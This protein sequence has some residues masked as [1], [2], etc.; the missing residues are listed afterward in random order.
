[1]VILDVTAGNR[2]IW[3]NSKHPS[4]IIFIDKEFG[5]KINQDIIAD[6]RKL[7]I[8]KDIQIDSIIFD[9][10]WGLNMPPWWVDKNPNDVT[11]TYYGDFKSKRELISYIHKA[12]K[13]FQQ[14]T[15]R[16]C[17][18][19]GERN[20]SLWKILPLFTREGWIEINRKEI[21]EKRNAKGASSNKNW[22]I[23]FMR[24]KSTCGE[25]EK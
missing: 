1:M 20:V 25:D 15:N 18:K 2:M 10:P 24:I 11:A 9:P 12:Q 13:E 19:W 8:R 16:L 7:P 14:Y 21:K 3:K 17:F 23:T 4:D 22:W 6:N 5:F